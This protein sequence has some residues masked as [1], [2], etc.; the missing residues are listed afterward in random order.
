MRLIASHEPRTAPYF[1]IASTAYV[2][3][4]GV[5]LQELGGSR[6]ETSS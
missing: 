4:V 3:Q 2:E 1:V 5:N 6:G